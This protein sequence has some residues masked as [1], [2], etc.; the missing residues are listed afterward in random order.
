MKS[1]RV[2]ERNPLLDTNRPYQ[3]YPLF[4]LS[5]VIVRL[6]AHLTVKRPTVGSKTLFNFYYLQFYLANAE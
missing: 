1:A 5:Q 4:I 3:V 6:S 2:F